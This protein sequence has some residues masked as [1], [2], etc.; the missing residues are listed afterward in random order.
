[1]MARF[2]K[3]VFAFTIAVA[4]GGG[5]AVLMSSPAEAAAQPLSKED[6]AALKQAIVACKAEAKG[7][8]VKWLERRKYVKGCV[9][10]ALKGRPS[11]DVGQV[12]KD[13]PEMK[14]LP[15]D[16]TEAI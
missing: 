13:H 4:L 11:I 12:L 3:T 14:G 9:K 2:A 16:P 8:K 7:K 5:G 1:M 6:K 10:E 15:A